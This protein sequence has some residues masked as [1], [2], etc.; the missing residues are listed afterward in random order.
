MQSLIL[1]RQEGR[2]G[3]CNISLFNE[4]VKYDH[5][6]P[7]SYLDS[8][9]G[10]DNW[11]ATCGRCNLKKSSKIFRNEEDMMMF[12][13]DMIISHGS[14]AEGWE[15]GTEHWQSKLMAQATPRD[16]PKKPSD[17]VLSRLQDKNVSD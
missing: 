16:T 6:I 17:W 15:E 14:F 11:V 8:S 10:K 13:N 4:Q 9:G 1:I 12:C 2:C 7:W 5:F 3:Y